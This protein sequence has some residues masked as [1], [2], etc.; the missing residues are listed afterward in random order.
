MFEKNPFHPA[1][2]GLLLLLPGVVCFASFLLRRA[3]VPHRI[4]QALCPALALSGWIVFALAT[5][6]LTHSFHASIIAST[7]VLGSLGYVLCL[8]DRRRL[9]DR[10]SRGVGSSTG[11]PSS[12]W[13]IALWSICVVAPVAVMSAG[14]CFHD[15]L[16]AKGHMALTRQIQNDYYPLVYL[17]F[18]DSR[19]YY[20]YAVDLVVAAMTATTRLR[21]QWCFDLLTCAAWSYLFVLCWLLG[22]RLSRAKHAGPWVAGIALLGS[23]LVAP[24]RWLTGSTLWLELNHWKIQIG[25]ELLRVPL[26]PVQFIFQHPFT[27][28]LPFGAAMLLL[29]SVDSPRRVGFR[30]VLLGLMLA[31]TSMSQIVVFLALLPTFVVCGLI[32]RRASSLAMGLGAYGAAWLLGSI[33]WGGR[34]HVEFVPDMLV[35]NTKQVALYNLVAFAALLPL[36]IAGLFRLNRL[37]LPLVLVISGGFLVPLIARY[38]ASQ[39]PI[40]IE[41]FTFLACF[42][43]AICVGVWFAERVLAG[44]RRRWWLVPI[45][46][47]LVC[48]TVENVVGVVYLQWAYPVMGNTYNDQAR[49]VPDAVIPAV[50]WLQRRVRPDELI[51]ADPQTSLAFIHQAGLPTAV[52]SPVCPFY[53]EV[54]DDERMIQ[55]DRLTKSPLT[56]DK[57]RKERIRWIVLGNSRTDRLVGRIARPWI[58]SGDVRIAK[59]FPAAV[60]LQVVYE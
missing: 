7:V 47:L 58:E 6:R 14:G 3:V 56:I 55:R 29:F 34:S 17:P 43:L 36:G 32:R 16:V 60:V 18:P 39:W 26:P 4:R 57:F 41:K 25:E 27:L 19:F 30:Q 49:T 11:A 42:A 5:A 12:V 13:R 53:R 40:N 20:H 1:Y 31:A 21:I 35:A 22:E 15:E 38:P 48:T 44:G 50:D 51:W 45:G 24:A 28:G 37:R 54:V 8:V 33:V 10:R 9:R 2:I 46:G 23:G 52:S 59:R